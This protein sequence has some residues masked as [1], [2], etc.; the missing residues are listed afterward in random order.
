VA[1]PGC[2]SLIIDRIT[3]MRVAGHVT[4]RMWSKYSQVRLDS[5]REKTDGGFQSIEQDL[6]GATSPACGGHIGW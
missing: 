5:V 4:E 1:M 2:I 3:A 6:Q